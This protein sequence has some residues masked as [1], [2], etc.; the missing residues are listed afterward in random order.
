MLQV[1]C[2]VVQGNL[3]VPTWGQNCTKPCAVP[4]CQLPSK[5]L[6]LSTLIELSLFLG[7]VLQHLLWTHSLPKRLKMRR[8]H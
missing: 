5:G 8:C 3:E 6:L 2:I 7:D 1:L 4:P